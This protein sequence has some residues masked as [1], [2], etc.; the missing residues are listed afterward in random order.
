[1]N[2][3][4]TPAAIPAEPQARL[5]L[6]RN[7]SRLGMLDG[8]WWPRS[9]D[10]A[11]ELAPLISALTD[12][13]GIVYRVGLNHATWDSHPRRIIVGGH[14]VK[15]G[16]YGPSDAHA[17]RVFGDRRHHLDLLL[18]PPE[19]DADSAAAAM[20]TA[21]DSASQARATDVLTAH[22]ISTDLAAPPGPTADRP[23]PRTAPLRGTTANGARRN[24]KRPGG[25]PAAGTAKGGSE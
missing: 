2:T 10:T 3:D 7:G 8:A 18:V 14:I 22:G 11:R 12:E 19:A 13:T 21:S 23:P 1:M 15:L 6:E 5:S 4:R 17:I 16:W 9:R 20:V 25:Q 24:G